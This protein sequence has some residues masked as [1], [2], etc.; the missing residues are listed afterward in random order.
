MEVDWKGCDRKEGRK[1]FEV[2]GR[3]YII[4]SKTLI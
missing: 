1:D 3:I 2:E 4:R